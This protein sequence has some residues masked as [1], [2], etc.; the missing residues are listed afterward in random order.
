MNYFLKRLFDRISSA[1]A[2]VIL[3]P[4]FLVIAAAIKLDSKGSVF[5]KQ[6][7]LLKNGRAFKMLKFR[8][9]VVNAE[10][11]GTGLFN[12]TNDPRVTRVGRFLRNSSLDEL[13]QLL[14]VLKGDMSLVGPR[15]CVTYELGDYDTLNARYKKRFTVLPGITGYAQV[16]GRNVI[17]W[18]QKVDLDNEY[19]DLFKKQGV[20]LDIKILFR[21]V[22]NVFAIQDIYEEKVDDSMND[23][24]SA[25]ASEWEIITRAHAVEDEDIAAEKS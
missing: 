1:L 6:E 22:A 20:W 12:Y 24:E 9:M 13:P 25:E 8:S 15:P 2:L 4:L 23:Q 19:I 11:M 7:R 18:D 10:S 5:F 21:T 17:S 14:H 3:S 16:S